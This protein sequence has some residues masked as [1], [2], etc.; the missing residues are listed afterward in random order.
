MLAY[1]LTLLFFL[2][3]IA[4]R[5]LPAAEEARRVR[6]TRVAIGCAAAG[7]AVAAALP[8]VV[9]VFRVPPPTVPCAIGTL[10][11]HWVDATRSEAFAADPQARRDRADEPP[12]CRMRAPR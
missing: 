10:T 11:C 1:A 6:L 2:S 9:P 5:S 4:H 7:L 8:I 3:P 12:T